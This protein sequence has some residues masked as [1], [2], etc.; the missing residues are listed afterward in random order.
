MQNDD[1]I[2]PPVGRSSVPALDEPQL[3]DIFIGNM[4]VSAR[5]PS[6]WNN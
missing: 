2:T 3:Y 4:T 6:G 1:R 5:V